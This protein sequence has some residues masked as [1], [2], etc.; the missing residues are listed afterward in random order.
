MKRTQIRSLAKGLIN[1]VG[2]DAL[3][4]ILN[5]LNALSNLM[6]K[7]KEFRD[8]I[9]SPNFTD[10]EKETILRAIGNKLGLKDETIKFVSNLARLRAGSALADII[11]I[12]LSIY[13]DKKKKAKVTVFT[14]FSI[15]DTY[16]GRLKASLNKLTGKD[17]DI[18]Y[19]RD[20]SLIGGMLIRV[21]S[22]MYDGSIKGQLRLLKNELVKG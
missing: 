20:E 7:N 13:L 12:A 6:L 5:E 8:L 16:E 9:M 10:A 3:P 18:E 22:S 19:V 14:P 2:L 21:G 15:G 1:T 17:V 11:K 4:V